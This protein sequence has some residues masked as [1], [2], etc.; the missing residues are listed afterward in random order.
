[1]LP[2]S[3][4][5]QD[6]PRS[7]PPGTK[8]LPLIDNYQ[9]KPRSKRSFVCLGVLAVVLADD[10]PMTTRGR[11]YFAR[12]PRFGV[13]LLAYSPVPATSSKFFAARSRRKFSCRPQRPLEENTQGPTPGREKKMPPIEPLKPLFRSLLFLFVVLQSRQAKW[14]AKNSLAKALMEKFRDTTQ[15]T[16]AGEE[17]GHFIFHVGIPKSGTTTIQC[18]L[19]DYSEILATN[20]AHYYLGKKCNGNL[21]NGETAIAGHYLFNYL[22]DGRLGSVGEQLKE[23]LDFHREHGNHSVIFSIEKFSEAITNNGG[24]KALNAMLRDW[25]VR[26]VVSYRRYFEWRASLFYQQNHRDRAKQRSMVQQVRELLRNPPVTHPSLATYHNYKQHN[27]TVY[28]FNFHD[29]GDLFVNFVCGAIPSAGNTCNFLQSSNATKGAER[30]SQSMDDLRLMDA[31]TRKNWNSTPKDGWEEL[32]AQFRMMNPRLYQAH[33]ECL[34]QDELARF[35]NYSLALE[36]EVYSSEGAKHQ[37]MKIT[38]DTSKKHRE[39]FSRF[40]DS[41]KHCELNANA[42]VEDSAFFSF[43]MR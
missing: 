13:L 4:Q 29:E 10:W 8:T 24:W 40:V 32:V 11:G 15:V 36:R 42:L 37:G 6:L 34:T 20:D 35:L 23:R 28:L 12:I 31:V 30:I 17:G 33:Q 9:T 1:M 27:F 38:P 3:K 41:R 19:S 16:S 14:F 43:V 2:L 7:R 25:K 18:G 22:Q 21:K 5:L 39:A 26:I